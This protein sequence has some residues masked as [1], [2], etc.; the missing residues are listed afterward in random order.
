MSGWSEDAVESL[1][2]VA[3]AAKAK[4][5]EPQ[6]NSMIWEVRAR[7]LDSSIIFKLGASD[8]IAAFGWSKKP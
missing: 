3:L 5:I 8:L 6:Q 4:I 2:T 1:R 7:D